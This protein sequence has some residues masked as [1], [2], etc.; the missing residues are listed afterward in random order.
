[1]TLDSIQN[2][3][4]DAD[5]PTDGLEAMSPPVAWL[6]AFRNEPLLLKPVAQTVRHLAC[7]AP[8]ILWS[9]RHVEQR[10]YSD[11]IYMLQE[12]SFQHLRM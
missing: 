7:M 9:R 12:P 11:S 6:H 4:R 10:T 3:I 1:M 2:P 5:L 8:V